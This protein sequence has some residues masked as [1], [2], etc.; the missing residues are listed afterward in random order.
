MGDIQKAL[1]KRVQIDPHEKLPKAY[2]DFVDL[3]EPKNAER[4]PEHQAE[5]I[6]HKTELIKGEKRKEPEMPWG[7]LYNMSA[8]ELIVLHK[9][10]AELCHGAQSNS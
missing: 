9:T 6:D 2:G 4:L 7:P 5:G 1:A 8:E 3:F 10:L